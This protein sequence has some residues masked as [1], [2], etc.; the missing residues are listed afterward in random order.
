M[1][2]LTTLVGGLATLTASAAV[3]EPETVTVPGPGTAAGPAD[4][5]PAPTEVDDGPA[6]GTAD[7]AP[8]TDGAATRD[9]P[10]TAPATSDPSSSRRAPTTAPPPTR[11][12]AP[13]DAEE[14]APRPVGLRIPALGVHADTIDLGL[15]PDGRLEVP[16][17]AARTG[18]WIGGTRPGE[19]GPG[20]IVGHVDSR[21]GPGVFA[22]LHRVQ[23]GMQVLVDR[24]DGTTAH[25]EVHGMLQVGKDEF[26]TDLVYGDTDQ[27]R[28]RL[29]TCGGAFDRD[30]RSYDDNVVVDLALLG[31]S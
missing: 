25:F 18:W 6:T 5:A 22:D 31:W 27:P 10:S 8:R 3:P 16:S 14:D 24:E 28:L 30:A 11:V 29:V 7:A 13:D 12:A 9:D 2:A 1:V 15:D 21:A 26:P 23:G 17:D 19:R 20:V 4:F